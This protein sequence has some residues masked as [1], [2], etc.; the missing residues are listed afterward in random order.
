MSNHT[1]E[2]RILSV[3][4]ENDYLAATLALSGEVELSGGMRDYLREYE[5]RGASDQ[6]KKIQ[7]HIRLAGEIALR[8]EPKN[9]NGIA[10]D[11]M[12]MAI[13]H[14]FK[15]GL[16]TGTKITDAVHEGLLTNMY[17]LRKLDEGIPRKVVKED[18]DI[19]DDEFVDGL[20]MIQWGGMGLDLVVG[21]DAK[22]L[23]N[24]LASN[25]YE[26]PEHQALYKMGVGAA[27]L[28][29]YCLIVDENV[30]SA[31]RYFKQVDP[32]EELNEL[33]D[34]TTGE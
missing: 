12:F 4:N 25:V 1:P 11:R 5:F 14:A 22:L 17:V 30:I 7:N 29:A 27:I 32:S 21:D 6:S 24:D 15:R 19:D 8:L 2:L 3:P 9:S 33:I 31:E 23:I 28:T 16:I 18:E 13:T 34:S 10:S 26:R 20:G